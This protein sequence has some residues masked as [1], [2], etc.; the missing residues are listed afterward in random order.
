MANPPSS[1]LSP[2]SSSFD[3]TVDS[4]SQ[5]SQ[6][7]LYTVPAP[8]RQ[9]NTRPRTG[10]T[11]NTILRHVPHLPQWPLH[12]RSTPQDRP[13]KG[14]LRPPVVTH[15]TID[16]LTTR[17]GGWHPE[18]TTHGHVDIKYFKKQQ[19]LPRSHNGTA[20]ANRY[21]IHRQSPPQSI[22]LVPI[23]RMAKVQS[24]E[25]STMS[26]LCLHTAP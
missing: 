8:G 24:T 2:T 19:A 1:T 25:Y 17:G 7:R 11:Y 23:T 4:H 5:T 14:L 22:R 10:A 12:T 9:F 3:L 20:T 26:L 21:N 18:N 16:W 6:H 13:H 15:A